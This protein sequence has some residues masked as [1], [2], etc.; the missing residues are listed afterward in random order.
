[1]LKFMTV[2]HFCPCVA[3]NAAPPPPSFIGNDYFC[4]SGLN[5]PWVDRQYIFYPNDPLW[6]G[7]DCPSRC[8]E[9]NNPPY[10]IKTLPAPTTDDI[11]L[12]I[13]AEHF[14][15]T[16]DSPIDQVEIYVQ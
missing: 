10:F 13:C 5:A 7:Q 12:R 14:G 11:E 3:S 8:C 16:E 15:A 2:G 6:D 1:M 4:E 9:F